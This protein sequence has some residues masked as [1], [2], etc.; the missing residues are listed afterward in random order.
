MKATAS[1]SIGELAK[2]ARVSVRTLH[3]YDEI[4]LLR[5]SDRSGAGYRLYCPKDLERL[6]QI[7]FFRELGIKLD[8]IERIL[9]DPKFD[10]RETLKA[11]RALL[12][13]RAERAR[14]LVE[15]VD[16]TLAAVAGEGEEHAMKPEDM[17]DG[18][19]PS[20]YEEEAK[21]KWGHT[22]AYAESKR[23]T[24]RYRK[25]DWQEVGAQA[26]AITER[27][28]VLA[29]A[30]VPPT[31]ARAMDVAEEHR[32]HISHW[33]Y[34]CTYEIHVGLGTMYVADPRFAANY[35]PRRPGLAQYI[36][37]AIAAN[38]ARAASVKDGGR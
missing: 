29:E 18:F 15:L 38:A 20:K 23:R 33:F 24:G 25:E 10:R 7:L 34:D 2:I 19:D 32:R 11:H 12:V 16:R 21:A 27:F 8:A 6:Q 30:G 35:E 31:D 28:A 9:S 1:Y 13:E 5:P 36:C 37:D 17:F 3:H 22:E 26:G 14:A 4:G